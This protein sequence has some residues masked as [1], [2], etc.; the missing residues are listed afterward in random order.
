[1]VLDN[2]VYHKTLLKNLTLDN[3]GFSVQTSMIKSDP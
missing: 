3:V 1:M 2:V